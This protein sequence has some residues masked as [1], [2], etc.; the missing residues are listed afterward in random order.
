MDGALLELEARIRSCGA[1]ES[2][3]NALGGWSTGA[4][5]FEGNC[6]W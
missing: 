6:A 1:V 5:D 4:T 3:Y 2:S